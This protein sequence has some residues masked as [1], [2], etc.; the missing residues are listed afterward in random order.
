MRRRIV[1]SVDAPPGATDED[2]ANYVCN[3]VET[4]GGSYHSDDP[5][6]DGVKVR[7]ITIR[8]TRYS[9]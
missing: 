8:N 7:F 4:W 2:L 1:I 6:F 5:L 3:A 9:K